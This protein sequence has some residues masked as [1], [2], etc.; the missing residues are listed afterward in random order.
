M[1]TDIKNKYRYGSVITKLLLINVLVFVIQSIILLIFTLSGR[2]EIFTGFLNHFYFPAKLSEFIIKP[3]SIITFQFLHDPLG[4]FHILFNMLYLYFFGRIILDFLNSRYIFPLYLTGG[5]IGGLL[6]MVTYNLSPAFQNNAVLFGA[7]ASVLAIVVAAA[8]LAPDYTVFLILI[9]AV[10]LKYIAFIAILIDIVSISARSNEGGHL[11]HLGGALA[12]FLFIKSYQRGYNW[13]NWYFKLEDRIK[14]YR[15]RKPKVV[16]V[17]TAPKKTKSIVSDDR[18][19]KLDA[20]LDKISKSGYE[21]LNA[22]EKEFLFT[23]S[24]EK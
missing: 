22:A 4:I 5:I 20:I 24:K 2:Q 11:S 18:Q 15:S 21:S 12:G 1:I 23:V 8:T 19:K 6:F 10:K 16:Y 17:N 13:F 3:W 14:N 9:G 7:S